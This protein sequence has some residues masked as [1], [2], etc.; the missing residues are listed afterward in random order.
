MGNAQ[1]PNC[2]GEN[3]YRLDEVVI[4][5]RPRVQGDGDE[6]FEKA[7]DSAI[8]KQIDLLQKWSRNSMT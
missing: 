2:C 7:N 1:N 6:V 3:G 8:W 5:Q 4:G